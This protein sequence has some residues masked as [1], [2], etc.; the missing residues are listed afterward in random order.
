M[1]A[2]SAAPAILFDRVSHAYPRVTS[3]DAVSFG[4]ASGETVALIGPSGCGKSTLLKM[5]AGLVWPRSGRV[6][7]AGRE[8]TPQIVLGVRQRLGYVIQSGGLFP[9]LSAADNV[10]LA[11]RYLDRPADWIAARVREL[12]DLV[13]LELSV[14]ER[15]PGDLSGGQRQRVSLMRAL[16]LDPDVLLFDEPLGALDPMVRHE[17]QQELK[18]LF[19]RLGKSV[20]LVTHDMAEAAFFSRKLVLMRAGRIVQQGAFEDLANAPAEEFVAAFVQAQRGR[21]E[22]P[23]RA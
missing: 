5:A 10:T 20:L 14:L 11:A 16:M 21:W 13:Q 2:M 3:V 4:V 18:R 15:F 23:Y 17:L 8:L 9:H 1:R 19:A 6:V 7:V 22:G 12:A